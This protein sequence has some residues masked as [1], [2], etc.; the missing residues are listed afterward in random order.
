MS[1][2][3]SIYARVTSDS[4]LTALIGTRITPGE[5]IQGDGYPY[6]V[7]NVIDKDPTVHLTGD[8]LEDRTLVQFDIVSD[9][10]D[11]VRDT[12]RALRVRLGGW[13][14]TGEGDRTIKGAHLT[15]ERDQHERAKDGSDALLYRSSV[16]FAIWAE[17]T[18]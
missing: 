10:Y 15:G 6:V 1:L 18:A 11:E 5:P 17:D 13:S 8:N 12:V 2:S 3:Q 4:P 14:A 7:Y 16:D 9:D